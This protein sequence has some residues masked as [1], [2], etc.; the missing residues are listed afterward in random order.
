ME[1]MPPG[2]VTMVYD[3]GGV[4]CLAFTASVES[5]GWCGTHGSSATLPP[6]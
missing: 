6:H 5:L 2:V 4:E 1:T 3:A